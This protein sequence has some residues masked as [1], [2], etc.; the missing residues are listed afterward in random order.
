[1]KNVVF[2]FFFFFFF[3]F[4]KIVDFELMDYLFFFLGFVLAVSAS[5]GNVMAF[6]LTSA[7]CMNC[8]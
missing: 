2:F 8:K 7:I 3:F 5:T 4:C 6:H 1:M